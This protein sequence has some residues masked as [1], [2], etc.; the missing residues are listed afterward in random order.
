MR[1]QAKRVH[2]E[3]GR[4]E[5]DS[6]RSRLTISSAGHSA[7]GGWG[8]TVSNISKSRMTLKSYKLRIDN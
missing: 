5:I 8:I 4:A 1:S 2:E 3:E 7:Q 6:E